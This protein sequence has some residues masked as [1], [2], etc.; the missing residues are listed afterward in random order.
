[1]ILRGGKD[2]LQ[3][4]DDN[5]RQ[6]ILM[7]TQPRLKIFR[8]KHIKTSMEMSNGKTSSHNPNTT[9]EKNRGQSKKAASRYDRHSNRTNSFDS[10]E[11]DLSASPFAK[12]PFADRDSIDKTRNITPLDACTERYTFQ[13]NAG[14]PKVEDKDD[15]DNILS[16]TMISKIHNHQK[17]QSMSIGNQDTLSQKLKTQDKDTSS[18]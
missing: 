12:S 10:M 15:I 6:E 2:K 16:N 14:N 3:E 9:A 7:D 1:M 17:R 18:C 11:R 4:T 13:P 5:R 8:F